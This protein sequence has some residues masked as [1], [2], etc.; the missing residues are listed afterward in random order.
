MR[1]MKRSRFYVLVA[2]AGLL[3]A[4]L[5]CGPGIKASKPTVVIIS[6]Q[7][8]SRLTLGQEVIVQSVA[9][10]AKGVGRVELWVDGQ[11]VHTQAVVP[12]ATSY[13]ASQ[14]WTPAIVGNHIIE[15]RAYNVDNTQSDPVQVIVAAAEGVG[16][17]TPTAGDIPAPP[18]ASPT[19]PDSGTGQLGAGA[20]LTALIGLNVRSGPGVDHPVIGGLR[21]GQA[22][23]ITGKNPEGTW[24]QI[25]YPL[26]SGGRG[27]VSGGA[28]YSKASNAQGVPVVEGPPLPA[29]TPTPTAT[30]TPT[31]TVPAPPHPS[32][33]VIYSFTA[34]RNTIT[35]GESVV[36][37]WDLANAQAAYL[38]YGGLEEAVVAPGNKTVSPAVTTVYT[39]IAR[40]EAG[41]TTA[42]LT[43]TVNPAVAQ[44]D[45]YVRRMDFMPPDMV[46]GATI[47]LNAMIATDIGPSGGPYFP[48]SHFRW[49]QGPSFPWQE[50]AC[51]ANTHYAQCSKTLTFSYASPGDYYVEVEAD[52]RAEI[53][54]TDETNNVKGWTI[55]VV[56]AS[57]GL[58][59]PI[60]ISPPHGSVFDYYPRTTTLE[61]TLVPGAA[62]YRV[63]V[64]YYD[65]A[66]LPYQHVPGIVTT[67]YT[68]DFV[69]AQPGRWRVRAVHASN[70]VGPASGWWEFTYLQ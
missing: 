12:P 4:M 30:P 29:G 66:W 40:N 33:P 65:G 55:T 60:Q 20:T 42:Q 56:P 57:G 69:G 22:A 19:V 68:F 24:W 58:S 2:L 3:V 62:S 13:T 45:L 15:V 46:V 49:R 64:E 18:P 32:K 5:A 48:A 38:R 53:A 67:N 43:I 16:G 11:P 47:S 41:E 26:D 10:D 39:L 1:N 7:A 21:E 17:A 8:G 28:Q 27:W 63:D 59:A 44:Y 25:V 50:E 23:Q 36:L 70:S 35:A 34:D 6:P 9:T 51:P 14:S 37:R 61:W 31:P 54:E 52:S